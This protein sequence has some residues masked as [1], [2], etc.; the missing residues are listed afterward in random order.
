MDNL[1]ALRRLVD[2]TAR[3][4][5]GVGTDQRTAP[6]PCPELTVDQLVTHLV[7]GTAMFVGALDP[8]ATAAAADWKSAG[9]QLVGVFEGRADLDQTVNLPYGEYPLRVVLDHAVAETA[10]HAA[11]L[12]HATGQPI[13]DTEVF[14]DVLARCR[15]LVG[16]EWRQ[17]GVL[18]PEVPAP[19]GASV[20][21]QL[22]AFAGRRI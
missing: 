22:L 5:D 15:D 9:A 11:D 20:P 18:G 16:D 6:T 4:V 21:E 2:E 8:G 1:T 7:E 14:D 19:A 10:I 3:L 17:D 12:A 13:T